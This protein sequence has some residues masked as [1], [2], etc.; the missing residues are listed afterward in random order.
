MRCLPSGTVVVSAVLMAFLLSPRCSGAAYSLAV[1]A[2]GPA[3]YWRF[4][5]LVTTAGALDASGFDRHGSYENA[6]SLTLGV[7]G[8]QPGDGFGGMGADSLAVA[9]SDNGHVAMPAG[10]LPTGSSPRTFTGWFK[11]TSNSA[12]GW[13]NYG[14]DATPNR[15]SI[16]AG[17]N[18]VAVAVSG[19]NFGVNNLG[20]SDGWHHFGVIFPD[21]ATQSDEW[22]FVV[23]GVDRTADAVNLAGSTQTVNTID[24]NPLRRIGVGVNGWIDEVAVFDK[25]LTVADIQNHYLAATSFSP[26]TITLDPTEVVRVA[27]NQ[28]MDRS[29]TGSDFRPTTTP[30]DIAVRERGNPSETGARGVTYLRFDF[31]DLTPA[32]VNG[33]DFFATFAIDYQAR[34]NGLNNLQVGMDVVD[35]ANAWTATSGD[36]PMAEWVELGSADHILVD[37]VLS[38]DPPQTM[39]VD[40]TADV[41]DWVTGAK[42]NNGYVIF[43]TSNEFQGAGF[44]NARIYAVP[45]PGAWLL[46]LTALTCG[47]LLRRRGEGKA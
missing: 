12:Q 41:R 30:Q 38:T 9:F 44:A 22:Q 37:N 3:A 11:Q 35:D 15:N 40:V 47:L 23:D 26:G 18:R 17:P 1:L 16:T 14:R 5:E 8:P 4:N 28:P 29:T 20:L 19:H 45:E 33:E 13:L 42:A 34:V 25:A 7:P 43:G 36:Y 46:L 32:I 24:D 39:F 6:G 27:W 31:S 10:F 2:D 21:G